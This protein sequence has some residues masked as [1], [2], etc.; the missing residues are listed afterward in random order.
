MLTCSELDRGVPQSF[1]LA[2]STAMCLR[3]IRY[4]FTLHGFTKCNQLF[5]FAV[6]RD[7]R[8]EGATR[9][10]IDADDDHDCSDA[11]SDTCD[12]T[13]S[14]DD[15]T[16]DDVDG[17]RRTRFVVGCHT[18]S[19]DEEIRLRLIRLRRSLGSSLSFVRR[20]C[21]KLI[22]GIRVYGSADKLSAV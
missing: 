11:V 17:V 6:N 2:L 10:G 3:V 12:S 22:F 15:D 18:S 9:T 13:S 4:S 20:G 1:R 7:R 16:V 14:A 21:S 19:S 5:L 8:S